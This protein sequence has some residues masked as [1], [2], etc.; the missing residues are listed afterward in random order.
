MMPHVWSEITP[1]CPW[2]VGYPAHWAMAQCVH[3]AVSATLMAGCK[4]M[5][6]T[7]KIHCEHP[8]KTYSVHDFEVWKTVWSVLSVDP[9]KKTQS[10]VDPSLSH[11]HSLSAIKPWV[12]ILTLW[13]SHHPF[14]T[15][16]RRHSRRCWDQGG[17]DPGLTR[18]QSSCLKP[19]QQLGP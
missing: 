13:Q 14:S 12:S 11:R 10:L 5:A 19:C 8:N 7:T 6:Q 2:I 18:R 16:A 4:G 15:A 3:L 17:R 9:M 1:S